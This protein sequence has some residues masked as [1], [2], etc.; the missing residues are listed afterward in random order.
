MK[1]LADMV[2]K[3][4]DITVDVLHQMVEK[5][6]EQ[7]LDDEYDDTYAKIVNRGMDNECV[8]VVNLDKGADK[9]LV[10][11]VDDYSVKVVVKKDGAMDPVD[12]AKFSLCDVVTTDD[13]FNAV[14]NLWSA[15]KDWRN[16]FC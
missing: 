14:V 15:L 8:R 1:K 12:S 3:E 10:F 7:F 13:F 2:V 11:T 4:N 9:K 5:C 16:V 6:I